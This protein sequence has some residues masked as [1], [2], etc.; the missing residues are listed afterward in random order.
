MASQIHDRMTEQVYQSP[1]TSFKV[2]A[3]PA[4][5]KRVP[6]LAEG[7]AALEAINKDMGL[8]FDK[9]DIEYY[10]HLF[11][12]QYKRDPTTVELFDIGQSNSEHSRHWFFGANLVIDGETMPA[13]LFK[14]VKDTLKANPGNSVIGFKDNSSAI[15]GGVVQKIEPVSAGSPCPLGP[16]SKDMDI[17]LTAETHNFPCSVAPYPGAETGAGGRIRDTHATGKRPCSWTLCPSSCSPISK[18]P[19]SDYRNRLHNGCCLCW[20]LYRQP[21][22]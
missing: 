10:L 9:Q 18:L 16:V 7:C 22:P 5:V 13:S 17:L 6:V 11:R 15:R 8:A 21:Q 14:L 12:D 2:D 19:R 3:I 20:L 4:P 1:L